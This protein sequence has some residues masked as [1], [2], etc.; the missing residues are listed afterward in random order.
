MVQGLA[1][2]AREISDWCGCDARGDSCL[3]YVVE[4]LVFSAAGSGRQVLKGPR[5]IYIA[6]RTLYGVYTPLRTLH[7][8][9]EALNTKYETKN[10][11]REGCS[12]PSKGEK[13]LVELRCTR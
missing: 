6:I 10:V 4:C 9:L 13:R 1:Y 8:K 2:R 5:G 11:R 12:V 7:P 3:T